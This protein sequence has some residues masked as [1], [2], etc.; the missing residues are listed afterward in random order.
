L[1]LSNNPRAVRGFT[2]CMEAISRGISSGRI[3]KVNA[4]AMQYC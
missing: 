2:K 1:I 4:L 3:F